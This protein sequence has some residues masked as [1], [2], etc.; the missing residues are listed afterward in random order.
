[1][2][3]T[4]GVK[5]KAARGNLPHM[6]KAITWQDKFQDQVV[7]QEN[8]YHFKTITCILALAKCLRRALKLLYNS[9]N[10]S[11]LLSVRIPC[12][13]IQTYTVQIYHNICY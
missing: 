12:T 2:C 6:N 11:E 3:T 5:H 8:L 9:S 7:Y 13:H 1:M 4:F 10:H